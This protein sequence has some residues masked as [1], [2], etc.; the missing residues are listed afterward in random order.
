MRGDVK[1]STSLGLFL[2]VALL[3]TPAGAGKA[4]A[5]VMLVDDSP[6]VV[7]GR[8]FV[9]AERVTLRTSL[10]GRRYTKRI[11]ASQVGRFTTRIANVDA[12]CSPFVVTA[13]G[14]RGSRATLRR[15]II[16]PPCGIPIAP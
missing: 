9:R 3:V 2:I 16:P 1:L 5:K 4:R 14:A 10:E 8:A 11:V 6:L 13:V 12:E 7:S 15:I